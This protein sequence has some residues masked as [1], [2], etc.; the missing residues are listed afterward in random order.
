MT[1]GTVLELG[2]A[3]VGGVAV[4]SGGAVV[5]TL[6]LS[7]WRT[8]AT[9]VVAGRDWVY[10]ARRRELT[11]RLAAEP[12][13]TARLRAWPTSWW[14]SRWAVALD[15]TV[16][17]V[18]HAAKGPGARRFLSGGRIVAASGRTGGRPALPTLH[19]ADGV[20]LDHQVFLLWVGMVL[21]RRSGSS[22]D[23]GGGEFGDDGGGDGGGGGD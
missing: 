8:S 7:P 12:A 6:H 20:P 18:Q 15:G 16:L 4:L 5:A 1:G 14:R 2:E 22:A 3:G 17:E 11:G 10:G 9:A 19:A 23:G 13:G 21:D